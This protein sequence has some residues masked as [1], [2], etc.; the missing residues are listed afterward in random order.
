M[1]KATDKVTDEV[2]YFYNPMTPFNL[3]S[4]KGV[5]PSVGILN[6]YANFLWDFLRENYGI[7]I[8]DDELIDDAN[9][10]KYLMKSFPVSSQAASYLP[11]FYPE[12][13]KDLGIRMQST[14]GVR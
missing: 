5:F 11:M 4:T 14:Y 12:L 1:L 8:K 2:S 3:I 13:A 6:N 9:P 10:I 7:I